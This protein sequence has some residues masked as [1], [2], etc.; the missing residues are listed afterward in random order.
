MKKTLIIIAITVLSVLGC[1]VSDEDT[2]Q[3]L[4]ELKAQNEKL[5]SEVDK[6]KTQISDLNEKYLLVLASLTDNKKEFDALKTQIDS[7]KNQLNQQLQRIDALSLQLNNQD[8]DIVKISQEL[9]ELKTSCDEI[10]KMI[11]NSLIGKSPIPTN[12]LVGWWPFNGNA[13]DESGN[14]LH[15]SI[16]N[17]Q[18]T[19][20]R[21]SN[22]NSAFDFDILSASF[23]KRNDE[24]YIPYNNLL[25]VRK[26]TVSVWI[27]PRRYYWFGNITNGSVIINRYQYGY[28]NP[29][30]QAWQLWF[31][32]KSVTGS[33]LGTNGLNETL[34]IDNTPLSLNQWSNIVMTYDTQNIKL[35]INGNLKSTTPYSGTMNIYG[36]SGISIGESNQANGFWGHTDG[37]IDD[38]GIW[39]RALTGEEIGKIYKGEK[40]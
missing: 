38:V 24:I 2:L 34:V 3:L 18:L 19:Q 25:N 11:E 7:L 28:S 27:F 6:M 16:V 31:D 10:K 1:K 36:N 39:D 29:N 15:A 17:T 40:F 26:I 30:G 13:N 22:P 32:S 14:N 9:A 4:R 12:G 37:K 20:D 5:L 35:Y 23:G 21:N 33:I 8:A